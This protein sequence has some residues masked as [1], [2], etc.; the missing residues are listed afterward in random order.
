[1]NRKSEPNAVRPTPI[2]EVYVKGRLI[3]TVHSHEDDFATA[4]RHTL[5]IR[6][7]NHVGSY[8][9]PPRGGYQQGILIMV[10]YIAE[11]FLFRC[12]TI[13]VPQAGI[14]S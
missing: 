5:R 11:R 9:Y 10:R 7:V 8:Y 6:Y 3:S 12:A 1:M 14:F 4:Y 13:L 2:S